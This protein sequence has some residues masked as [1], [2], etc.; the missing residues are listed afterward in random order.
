MI[1]ISIAAA[2]LVLLAAA[3]PG[4]AADYDSYDYGVQQQYGSYGTYSRPSYGRYG[5]RYTTRYNARVT[6]DDD[7]YT[8]TEHRVVGWGYEGGRHS[9]HRNWHCDD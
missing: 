9:F 6:Y 1:R 2:S 5:S 3:T 8:V 4:F 7:S